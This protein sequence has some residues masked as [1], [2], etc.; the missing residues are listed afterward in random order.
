MNL[1]DQEPVPPDD[2]QWTLDRA[3]TLFLNRWTDTIRGDRTAIERE[4]RELIADA[5]EQG[6]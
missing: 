5:K 4:L 3:V 1:F 2:Y 6:Q